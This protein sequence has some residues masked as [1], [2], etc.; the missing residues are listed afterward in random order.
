MQLDDQRV[1]KGVLAA[2]HVTYAGAP[3]AGAVVQTF[4]IGLAPDCE[5]RTN[6]AAGAPPTFAS[7]T[8]DGVGSYAIYLPDPATAQ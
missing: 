7:A 6:F 3:L 5:D 1:P 8:S 2:G 4:C